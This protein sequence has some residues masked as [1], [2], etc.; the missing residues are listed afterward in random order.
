MAGARVAA[1]RSWPTRR[2]ADDAVTLCQ[3]EPGAALLRLAKL[4][5]TGCSACASARWW[6]QAGRRCGA[7]NAWKAAGIGLIDEIAPGIALASSAAD[8][9]RLTL[10]TKAGGFGDTATLA[11]LVQHLHARS[12]ASSR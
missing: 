8:S 5:T 7:G 2:C 11:M 10:V 4:A 9:T 12:E 1:H 6:Q 3:H